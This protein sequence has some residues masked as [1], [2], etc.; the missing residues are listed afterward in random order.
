M[1]RLIVP[2][3]KDVPPHAGVEVDRSLDVEDI[4]RAF[5]AIANTLNGNVGFDNM[6]AGTR[7]S[8]GTAVGAVQNAFAQGKSL[9]VLRGHTVLPSVS[10]IVIGITALS[11]WEPV[12]AEAIIPS[13]SAPTVT[14]YYGASVLAAGVVGVAMTTTEAA[15]YGL[16]SGYK[17]T[18][19][20]FAVS[21][22]P[23]D[24]LIRATSSVVTTGP[25]YVTCTFK[26]G[27]V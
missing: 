9:V 23:A 21:S 18:F 20:S 5:N 15:K 4:D 8:S 3:F 16:T 17:V 22:V 7:F 6:A 13:A 10:D 25:S 12:S 27:H 26:A 19:T 14:L 11:T 24:T 1:S 2:Q